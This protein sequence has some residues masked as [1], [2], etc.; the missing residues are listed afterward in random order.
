LKQRTLILAVVLVLVVALT[1]TLVEINLPPNTTQTPS[2]YFG[3][4]VGFGDEND[5][6]KVAD[7]VQGY[8]NLIIIG[9]LAV[10]NDTA[11][12][13]RVC[14]YLYERG[15]SFII[16]INYDPVAPIGPD[17]QFF[18][19]T[20]KQWGNKMLGA[21]IFD[22]PGGKQLDYAPDTPHYIDKPVKQADNYT[23]AAQQFVTTLFWSLVAYTGPAYY[24]TPTLPLYTSDYALYWFDNL[25]GYNVV[26]GEF[27]GNQSRQLA[28]ALCRGAANVQHRDW[29]T[30][31]T[32]KYDQAPFLE[33]AEQLYNDMVLAYENDAKYIVVF[34]SPD[35]QTA[36]TD[37]GILTTQHLDAMKKFW[38]Y[39]KTHPEPAESP[40]N[41]AYVLPSDYGFGFRNPNDTIWGLFPADDLS[42]QIWTDT[43]N[44]VQQYGTN[45][46]IVFETWIDNVPARL[47]YDKLIF[48]NGT[49]IGDP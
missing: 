27:V 47:L 31:I 28:V 1:A 38:N 6:Y 46:D 22:E 4:D 37:L 20:A 29:G 19:E 33:D 16:Y 9:A 18:S 7:A 3:V 40:A 10:T 49:I 43:N 30:M 17:K 39:A 48:W 32:W 24:N 41:V 35:N 34:N 36:T 42:A 13:T 26:F 2:I 21:Y 5:V 44:L 23:D 25:L 15:F 45:L 12:L 8:A 14:N 11:K